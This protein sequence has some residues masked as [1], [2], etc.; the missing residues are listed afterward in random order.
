MIV[1]HNEAPITFP[2]ATAKKARETGFTQ[3]HNALLLAHLVV[4]PRRPGGDN[5]LHARVVRAAV[6]VDAATCQKPL[7][8]EK[9]ARGELIRK[10]HPDLYVMALEAESASTRYIIT[11]GPS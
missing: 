7:G 9:R 4:D 2:A 3:P 1:V 10:V 8:D 5:A 6:V 11:S